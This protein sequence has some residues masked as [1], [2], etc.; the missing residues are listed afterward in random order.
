MSA[1]KDRECDCIF[2]ERIVKRL[3]K[4][5]VPQVNACPFVGRRFLYVMTENAERR[6]IYH[7]KK[8]VQVICVLLCSMMIGCSLPSASKKDAKKYVIVKQL[9]HASIDEIAVAI[10]NELKELDETAE[11]EIYSGQNDQ[12]TLM[13]IGKQAVTDG[14]DVIIPIGT[15][16]AQ[17][18]VVASEDTEIPV[19]YATISDPEAASLTGIDRVTGTSDALN[20]K[21]FVDMMLKQNPNLQ[22][23]GLLYSNSEANSQKPIA[24]VKKILDEKKIKYIEATANTSQEVIAA[25]SSLIASKVDAVFTPTD[26]VIMS[27]ELAIYEAF[28]NANIPHYAGADSFVRSGAFAT[29]GVNYTDAGVKTAKLA[30]EVL[31]PGFKK[32]EEFIT[33]DGGI[34]TVNTEVAEKLGVN[35]DI[36][37]DFGQVVTVETTGK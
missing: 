23:V 19:V 4:K 32:T 20:T 16:A 5:V 22:T 15:L 21:Q 29:C 3:L 25:A 17:T 35:P 1:L 36:F 8:L 26:N 34:I 27:S 24:E 6:R 7:M 12:S 10:E 28:I 13:Q 18:M 11:V 31:Q 37:A 30:Y 33:L 9:D 2:K 14:A